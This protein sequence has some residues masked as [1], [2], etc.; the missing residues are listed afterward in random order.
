MNAAL[1]SVIIP[2]YNVEWCV[3][4]AIDSVLAQDCKPLEI[5]VVDDGSTDDTPEILA[6]YGNSIRVISKENGGLSSARNAGIRESKGELIAFLDADDWWMPEKLSVQ[7]RL[8]REQTNLGFCSTCTLIK[9]S[10]GNDLGT[11]DCPTI[12]DSI[13][14]TIFMTHASVAGSGSGVL[15]RRELFDQ[16]G[17]FDESLPSLEDIDMWMRLAAISHYACLA[18]P[19]T[20][21]VKRSDSMSGNLDVMRASAIQVMKKNR[22]FLEAKDRGQFWQ[23]A[24]AGVL[25]DY[26]KWEYRAGRKQ[27]AMAHL[28]EAFIRAPLSKGRLTLGLFI[29]MLKGEKI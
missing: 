14:K 22:H 8:M 13:L 6:S 26:A 17:G 3:R 20:V 25:S 28:L 5:L 29:A 15:V 11:W 10:D 4:R 1:V 24:Y 21:I 23:S 7:V 12:K 16:A 19:L 27:S 9:D 2:A 18:E